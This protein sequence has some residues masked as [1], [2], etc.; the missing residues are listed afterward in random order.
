MIYLDNMNINF[1]FEIQLSKL[2]LNINDLCPTTNDYKL[3]KSGLS[4]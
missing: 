3:R 1:F 4:C 2:N